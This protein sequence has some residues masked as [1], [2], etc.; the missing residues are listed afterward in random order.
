MI[1]VNILIFHKSLPFSHILSD[2]LVFNTFSIS[3][4]IVCYQKCDIL[5]IIIMI[6]GAKDPLTPT[7]IMCKFYYFLLR[8]SCE[9]LSDLVDEI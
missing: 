9:F 6:P 1:Y 2:I 7:I 3:N 8:G 5:T 4:K